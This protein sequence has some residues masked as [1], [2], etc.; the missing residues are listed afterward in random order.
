MDADYLEFLDSILN[1]RLPDNQVMF[2]SQPIHISQSAESFYYR[3]AFHKVLT[4]VKEFSLV[5]S[6]P[7]GEPKLSA[8]QRRSTYQSSS[9]F[10]PYCQKFESG[11]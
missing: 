9:Q 2:K 6:L 5:L 7:G 4:R 8:M 1:E 11:D 10:K 3:E